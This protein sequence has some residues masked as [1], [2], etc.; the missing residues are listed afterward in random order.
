MPREPPVLLNKFKKELKQYTDDLLKY[1]NVSE[2][3]GNKEV[4][5]ILKA[6]PEAWVPFTKVKPKNFTWYSFYRPTDEFIP[7]F[8]KKIF[9]KVEQLYI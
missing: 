2:M 7:S 8:T 9:K 4:T 3:I 6:N 1:S 5:N